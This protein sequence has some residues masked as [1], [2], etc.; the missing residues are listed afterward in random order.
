[1]NNIDDKIARIS[2][3]RTNKFAIASF[4]SGIASLL[5]QLIDIILLLALFQY[6]WYALLSPISFVLILFIIISAILALLFGIT[7]IIQINRTGNLKGRRFAITGL[8]CGCEFIIIF[9]LFLVD[10]TFLLNLHSD[11]SI[12]F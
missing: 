12:T 4:V 9:L 10:I 8:I 11:F 6:A 7:A 1:M 3:K 2:K 5:L